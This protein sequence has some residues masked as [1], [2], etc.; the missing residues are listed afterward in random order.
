MDYDIHARQLAIKK[1]QDQERKH[2]DQ[3]SIL[4]NDVIVSALIIIEKD[5]EYLSPGS[6]KDSE[7]VSTIDQVRK[8]VTTKY[9]VAPGRSYRHQAKAEQI[10]D[11]AKEYFQREDATNEYERKCVNLFSFE[12]VVESDIGTIISTIPIYQ[13][14]S[15]MENHCKDSE[16]VGRV[17]RKTGTLFLKLMEY[18]ETEHSL[19]GNERLKCRDTDGNFFLFYINPCH[20]TEH[21]LEVGDCFSLEAKVKGHVESPY[22]RDLSGN[23][24]HQTQLNYVKVVKNY[25]KPK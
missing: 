18:Q 1:L 15:E 19:T 3:N 8:I 7:F 2:P 5:T 12:T 21:Q 25:G 11:W 14:C 16:F 17:G 4:I 24:I 23:M 6:V 10:V 20:S 13:K 22:D 9:Q